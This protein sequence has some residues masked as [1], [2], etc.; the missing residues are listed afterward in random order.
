MQL[1]VGMILVVARQKLHHTLI[2]AVGGCGASNAPR[3]TTHGSS[4]NS[5]QVG[6]W[7]R[8]SVQVSG[9]CGIRVCGP[10]SCI[11]RA[12][13]VSASGFGVLLSSRRRWLFER[14]GM[15]GQGCRARLPVRNYHHERSPP[16]ALLHL[17][18]QQLLL[19]RQ[20]LFCQG[21][22]VFP[23]VAPQ[24]RFKAEQPVRKG[25]G[26]SGRGVFLTW[27][28]EGLSERGAYLT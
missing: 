4:A 15:C 21:W 20:Q 25:E 13:V 17:Q 7:A 23:W 24:V 28:G 16:N 22:R 9:P 3:S 8:G 5:I 1:S 14:A 12:L 18:R 6:V 2:K 26:L 27:N 19:G 10:C 11:V